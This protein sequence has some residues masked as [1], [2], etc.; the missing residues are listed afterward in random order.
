MT[1][2]LGNV[3]WTVPP[4][5][6]VTNLNQIKVSVID[7]GTITLDIIGD[8][9]TYILRAVGAWTPPATAKVHMTKKELDILASDIVMRVNE[10]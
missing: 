5:T 7:N 1:T 3:I 2:S 4:E 6:P 10:F 8:S 9:G